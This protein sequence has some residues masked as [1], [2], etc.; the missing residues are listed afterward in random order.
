MESTPHRMAAPFYLVERFG[1]Q[2]LL[3]VSVVTL[4]S[5]VVV[6]SISFE[7][8]GV[9]VVRKLWKITNESFQSTLTVGDQASEFGTKP[10]FDLIE[11]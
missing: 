8:N 4:G 5:R 2:K 11:S 9:D 1:K 3:N 7:Q 10:L 6:L